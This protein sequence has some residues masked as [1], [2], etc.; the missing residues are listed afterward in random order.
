MAGKCVLVTGASS[1]CG[2]AIAL[3]F[4]RAGTSKIA[5]LARR[6]MAELTQQLQ[7]EASNNGHPAPQVL[8]LRADQTDQEQVEA[9]AQTFERAFGVLD[10]LVN[11]AGYM[12]QWKPIAQSDPSE[13]WRTWEVNVKGPYLV[14][15]SFI[16]LLLQSSSK[17]IIQVTSVG[18]LS[19][20]VGAS[21]YQ[22]TKTA[23]ARMSNHIRMEYGN[24]GVLV[25]NLHPGG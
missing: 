2:K 17:T 10:V 5:I 1:G 4:A 12:E 23:L 8:T 11:N 15:R 18:A 14:C 7:Q 19:T 25:H 21:A 6:E 24:Q 9:A 3:A 20:G 16:S 22:G 13:W